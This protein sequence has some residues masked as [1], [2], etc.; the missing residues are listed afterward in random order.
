[1]KVYFRLYKYFCSVQVPPV[2]T[3]TSVP[4]ENW[5]LLKTEGMKHAIHQASLFQLFWANCHILRPSS[6]R[7]FNRP[8]RIMTIVIIIVITR[9]CLENWRKDKKKSY[10]NIHSTDLWRTQRKK[11]SQKQKGDTFFRTRQIQYYRSTKRPKINYFHKIVKELYLTHMAGSSTSIKRAG[12]KVVLFY[13]NF[14]LWPVYRIAN[15]VVKYPNENF[16]K[17]VGCLGVCMRT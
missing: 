13:G 9:M 8:E 3:R 11:K 2:S 15:A 1:M 16:L 5:K 6:P 12:A 7:Y 14:K 4:A 10:R 17:N